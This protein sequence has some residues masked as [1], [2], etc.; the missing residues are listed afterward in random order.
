MTDP[1]LDMSNEV[2]QK[3]VLRLLGKAMANITELSP[4]TLAGAMDLPD[5]IVTWL[6]DNH[7]YFV[8]EAVVD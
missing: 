3:R 1:N 8:I 7:A 6:E 5:H 2:N 4:A